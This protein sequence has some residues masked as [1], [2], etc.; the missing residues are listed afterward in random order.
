MLPKRSGCLQRI[1]VVMRAA[2]RRHA[3]QPVGA[4][5]AS[6]AAALSEQCGCLLA[7]GIQQLT[8]VLCMYVPGEG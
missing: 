6:C 3:S 5:T 2:P 1:R 4:V 8:H 7:Y